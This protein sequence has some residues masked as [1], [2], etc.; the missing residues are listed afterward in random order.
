MSAIDSLKHQIQAAIDTATDGGASGGGFTTEDINTIKKT[1]R[2]EFE[3]RIE[4]MQT[5]Q[6]EE[7]EQY[8]TELRKMDTINVEMKQ[9][10]LLLNDEMNRLK[11]Q[12]DES[13]NSTQDN[14]AKLM[15]R[16]KELNEQLKSKDQ[17]NLSL[18]N[19]MMSVQKSLGE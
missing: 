11:K 17:T 2:M 12:L 8:Q 19:D 18:T 9:S 6:K 16:V 1:I 15:E 10:E 14:T 7:K 4:S 5:Q 3:A 13:M